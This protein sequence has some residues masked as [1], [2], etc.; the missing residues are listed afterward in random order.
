MVP[1]NEVQISSVAML[2]ELMSRADFLLPAL[3]SRWTTLQR[4][5]EVREGKVWALKQSKVVYRIC[6]RPPCCRVLAQKLDAYLAQQQ[7]PPSG[8]NI[9]K[10][11]F[12][13]RPWLIIAVA[14]LSQGQDEI[15]SKEYVPPLEHMRKAAPQNLMVS[16][17][18]G[19][20]DVPLALRDKKGKRSLRM[21][22][23]SKED[24][25]KAQL[26]LMQDRAQRSAQKEQELLKE[27]ERQAQKKAFKDKGLTQREK[28]LEEAK[29]E[30]FKTLQLQA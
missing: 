30:V 5:L 19:L 10:E 3:K 22:T 2:H 20:L 17:S 29:G 1:L 13:D 15:F 26:L 6:T 16:N 9:A 12:P 24:K 4:L 14:T 28:D 23:L 18:D 21:A 27:I 8:I 25:L 7:L 11:K